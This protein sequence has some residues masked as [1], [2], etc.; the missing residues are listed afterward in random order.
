MQ[1]ILQHWLNPHITLTLI[2]PLCK[3]WP[4]HNFTPTLIAPQTKIQPDPKCTLTL[5]C[6]ILISISMFPKALF[7]I[8]YFMLPI[9]NVCFQYTGY[10]SK[11]LLMFPKSN[12]CSQY[13]IHVSKCELCFQT[14]IFQMYVSN[15]HWAVFVSLWCLGVVWFVSGVVVVWWIWD[16]N[17][18]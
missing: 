16:L 14:T 8:Y 11:R 6:I 17:W 7:P 1:S 13:P 9:L 15:I 12:L 18:I 5:I 3:I 4:N 2:P 10:V